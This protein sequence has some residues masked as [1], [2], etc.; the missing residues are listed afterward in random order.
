MPATSSAAPRI[1]GASRSG[2]DFFFVLSGFIITL[3]HAGDIGRPRRL[4]AFCGKRLLRIYPAYWIA[5]ALYLALLLASPTPG[6]AERGLAYVATS[7]LLWPDTAEPIL[8]VGWSLR[9]EL[10]FY[11]LFVVAILHRRFGTVLFAGWLAGILANAAAQLWN[12]Q[13]C[14]T[15]LAGSLL[16]RGLNL[17]FFFGIVAAI[18]V[19]RAVA[20]RAGGGGAVLFMVTALWEALGTPVMH[21]WPVRNVAYATG[22]A[23]LLH[24]LATLDRQGRTLVP[25]FALRVRAAVT[26]IVF[27]EAVEQPLLRGGRRLLR[28]CGAG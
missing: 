5:L 9:H 6:H 8:D 7:F 23:A 4:A 24:G 22:A 14:F 2:L 3:I 16:F 28:R 20:R 26:G 27:S 19:G 10:L 15:G 17:E 18:L 21:E 25:A 13:P 12:G 1:S 11:A